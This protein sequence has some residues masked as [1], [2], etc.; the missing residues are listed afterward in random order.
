VP[1]ETLRKSKQASYRK[2]CE[3]LRVEGIHEVF[4]RHLQRESRRDGWPGAKPL[5]RRILKVMQDGQYRTRV[6]IAA[7]INQQKRSQRWLFKCRYGSKS[8]L[9]N[10]VQRGLL[11]RSRKQVR[12]GTG[13][14][15]SAY[16]YW[17]PLEV[18]RGV[19]RGR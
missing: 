1:A 10:L 11:K 5:E 2:Q 15:Y 3:T 8:A 16:E 14:G 18:I 12:R 6:E 17:M 13:K 7:A 4:K 19:K 9:C